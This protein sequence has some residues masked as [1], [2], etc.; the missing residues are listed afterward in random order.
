MDR[1]ISMTP[2]EERYAL[3]ALSVVIGLVALTLLVYWF[4]GIF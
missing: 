4:L 2:E 3:I 1:T